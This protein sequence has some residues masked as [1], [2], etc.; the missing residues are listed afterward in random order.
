MDVV[1]QV[2]EKA[3]LSFRDEVKGAATE[4]LQ[5][6]RESEKFKGAARVFAWAKLKPGVRGNRG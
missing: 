1:I 4:F 3:P 6:K 5:G 2:K